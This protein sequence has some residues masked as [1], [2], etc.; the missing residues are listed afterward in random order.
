MENEPQKIEYKI[1]GSRV[2]ADG[3]G[4][5]NCMNKV[6]ATELC[7]K[8]N[9]LEHYKKEYTKITEKLDKLTKDIKR[10][11]ITVSTVHE[12]LK[13]IIKGIEQWQKK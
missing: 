2:F 6:T 7:Q 8:L 3:G 11:N 4:S 5:Y 9:E 12:E 1:Q 13:T 10:L